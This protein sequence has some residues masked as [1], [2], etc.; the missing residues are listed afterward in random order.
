MQITLAEIGMYLT[1]IGKVSTF[2][3]PREKVCLKK[4]PEWEK[5]QSPKELPTKTRG[6]RLQYCL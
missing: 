3:Q 4:G 6:T 2:E 5:A 1:F